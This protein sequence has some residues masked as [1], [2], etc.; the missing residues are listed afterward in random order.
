LSRDWYGDFDL[1]GNISGQGQAQSTEILVRYAGESESYALVLDWQ[2]SKVCL[3]E[4]HFGQSRHGIEAPLRVAPGDAGASFRIVA[5]ENRLTAVI[6]PSNGLESAGVSLEYSDIKVPEGRIGLGVRNGTMTYSRLSIAGNTTSSFGTYAFHCN[7]RL[8][9]KVATA[10]LYRYLDAV[11]ASEVARNQHTFTTVQEFEKYREQTILKLRR[12]LG[13]DP[14]PERTCLNARTVGTVDR[15]DFKIEKVVFES[16]PGFLVDALLYIP[17]NVKLPAPG[18]LS[19]IGHYDDEGFFL[20]AEQGRCIGLVRKGYVVLTYDPIS[21]G[22]RKWLGNG[23]HDLLR[24]KIILSG[25]EVSG[26]MFWDSIRAIDYLVS[27][28]EVDAARI[29]VTGVSGGGFN[30]LYTAVLDDRVKAV[31]PD[32]YATTIEALVKRAGAGCCSYL[33]DLTRYAEVTEVYSLI[34]PRK[35][36]ILGGY[37]DVLSD[38]ILDVYQQAHAVYSLFGAGDSI[39]YFLDRDGGHVYSKPMRLAMYRYFNQWLKGINDPEAASE[40]IDPEDSLIS[41]ESGILRVFAPG[42]RGKDVIDLEREYLARNRMKYDSPSSALAAAAVQ[43]E[44]RNRLIELMGEMAPAKLPVVV[45]DDQTTAPGS[46]RHMVLKTERDLPVAVSIYHPAKGAPRQG[47][48]VYFTMQDSYGTSDLTCADAV[49]RLVKEGYTVAVPHVRGTFETRVD[50]M[51]S[52]ELYTMAFGKHLFS[53]RIY[54]LQRV[55]DYLLAQPA[56]QSPPLAVW[57]EGAREGLMALYLAAVDPRV[58]AVISSHGLVTYQDIVDKDG[59]PDFDYYVPGIL[60]F[61]DVPQIIGAIAP[62]RVFISAPVDIDS[63]RVTLEDARQA[64]SWAQKLYETVGSGR[65]LSVVPEEDIFAD[66]GAERARH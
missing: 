34:A 7:Y 45:S 4:N 14:W 16:Q 53:T 35:L 49:G 27:R 26:L 46:T 48:M 19:T 8:A 18:V 3:R 31:A 9:Q 20:W 37:M 39:Q 66:V 22:E 38:R 52:V 44:I 50:D 13:L 41:R 61:A 25:M 24:Q 51:G 54:D 47:L 11:G 59:R 55:I 10:P 28:P 5:H 40:S 6:W 62:R 17:I 30:A 1:T 65:R 29:G 2:L 32:G 12:S 60:K 57:G 15:K 63:R 21:Q 56:Y 58:Q 36:L 42:E 43:G 33:P 64:Y 23:N